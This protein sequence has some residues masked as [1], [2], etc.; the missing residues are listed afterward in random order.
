MVDGLLA[1]AAK[2]VTALCIG[3]EPLTFDKCLLATVQART[4]LALIP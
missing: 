3:L 4:D 1:D 2:D